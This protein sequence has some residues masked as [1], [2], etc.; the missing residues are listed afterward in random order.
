M[1]QTAQLPKG[2]ASPTAKPRNT[3]KNVNPYELLIDHHDNPE[4]DNPNNPS[5]LI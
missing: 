2:K 3:P 4:P 5:S 1:E